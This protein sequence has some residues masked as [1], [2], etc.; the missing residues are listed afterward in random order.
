MVLGDGDQF[1]DIRAR[2]VPSVTGVGEPR[3][4]AGWLTVGP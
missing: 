1:P 4:A 3:A 2:H